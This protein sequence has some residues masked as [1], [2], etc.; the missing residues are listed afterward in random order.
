[1]RILFKYILWVM[2]FL[3]ACQKNELKKP[4]DVSFK[5][6]I[7]RAPSTSG[8]LIFDEGTINLAA[9][10]VEGERQEGSDVSF[11]KEFSN[12]LL[13]S[14][15]PNQPISE[16][17]F[18]IPQG[19]Y[20]SLAI[21]FETFDDN[22][23]ITIVCKGSYTNN[24]GSSIP[25]QFEFMSSEYFSMEAED[26][27]GNSDIVLDKDTPANAFIVFDPIYWFDIVPQN[28]LENAETSN[29]NGAQTI[30]IND[31]YNDN[32]YEMVVTR[33]EESTEITFGQ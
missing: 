14:F 24:S 25:L 17:D 32:I 8:A 9:F 27:S 22:S 16:I 1:M 6:D 31:S 3:F 10:D 29:V 4:T 21:S 7:N 12:G 28:L 2:P 26:D 15:D 5:M 33:V 19:V 11:S 23:D 13:V 18:D 30:L 20:K